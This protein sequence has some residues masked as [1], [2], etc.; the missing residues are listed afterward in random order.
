M[1]APMAPGA[2]VVVHDDR[3]LDAVDVSVFLP[4]S[5]FAVRLIDTEGFG[6]HIALFDGGGARLAGFP[7]LDH[8]DAELATL[9]EQVRDATMEAPFHD[10][11]Q[12]WELMIWRK[13]A[14]FFVLQGDGEA[15]GQFDVAFRVPA[16]AFMAAWTAAAQSR[17]LGP[18][19]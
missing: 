18:L 16:D 4:V 14:D 10:M 6:K 8:A 12:S 15:Y 1:L 13:G 7:W 11:E 17:Q 3:D 19:P 9:F 5:G 2:K